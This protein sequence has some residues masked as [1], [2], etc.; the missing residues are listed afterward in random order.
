MAIEFLRVLLHDRDVLL[1][2]DHLGDVSIFRAGLEHNVS[3]PWRYFVVSKPEAGWDCRRCSIWVKFTDA[4]KEVWPQALALDHL[5]T[6]G[7]EAR[8]C[9]SLA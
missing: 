9:L 1:C 8:A 2:G 5:W 6:V 3:I 7:L 4:A